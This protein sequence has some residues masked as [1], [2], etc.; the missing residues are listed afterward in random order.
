MESS[1]LPAFPVNADDRLNDPGRAGFVTEVKG[2][3]D[4]PH[5]V[6]WLPPEVEAPSG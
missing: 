3:Q 1:D 2:A 6:G 5:R 4:V